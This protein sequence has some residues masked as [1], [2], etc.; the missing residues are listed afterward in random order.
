MF[1]QQMTQNQMRETTNQ[2]RK[3]SKKRFFVVC[4]LKLLLENESSKT[5]NSIAKCIPS[6]RNEIIRT[7]LNVYKQTYY[8]L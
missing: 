7:K 2:W 5:L 3:S 1:L 8:E 4:C 6:T